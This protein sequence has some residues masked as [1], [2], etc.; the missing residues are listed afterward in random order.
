MIAFG[1]ICSGRDERVG[2]NSVVAVDRI[3]GYT[4]WSV[5]V[6]E[7][8]PDYSSCESSFFRVQTRESGILIL[9]T[10]ADSRVMASMAKPSPSGIGLETKWNFSP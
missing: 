9:R 5:S 4:E 2:V 6:L 10:S 7:A 3:D 8:A 1:M